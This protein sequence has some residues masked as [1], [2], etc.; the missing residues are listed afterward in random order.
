MFYSCAFKD[1]LQSWGGVGTETHWRELEAS[2]SRKSSS[3]EECFMHLDR[4][5][6]CDIGAAQLQ[7]GDGVHVGHCRTGQRCPKAAKGNFVLMS[8]I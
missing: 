2:S 8:C 6:L 5:T 7:Y 1:R 3:L 4:I